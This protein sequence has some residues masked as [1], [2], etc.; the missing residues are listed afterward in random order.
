MLDVSGKVLISGGLAIDA[1]RV[2]DTQVGGNGGKFTE[3]QVH[4]QQLSQQNV[5]VKI[6]CILVI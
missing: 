5:Y 3:F 4:S 1:I 6:Q 2:G